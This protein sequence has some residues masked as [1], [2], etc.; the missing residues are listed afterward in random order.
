MNKIVLYLVL[1]SC[2]ILG[3]SSCTVLNTYDKIYLNDIDMQV[4]P[5]ESEFYELSIQTY[6]EGATS[7]H[8]RKSGGGC[9]C[10]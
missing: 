9:G 1:Y 4:N 2:L 8:G 10:Y 5:M 6:R 7:S 3:T